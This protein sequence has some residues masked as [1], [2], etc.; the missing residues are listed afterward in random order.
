MEDGL[1]IIKGIPIIGAAV[2]VG[3]PVSVRVV[4]V[5]KWTVT[6]VVALVSPGAD[7]VQQRGQIEF[8]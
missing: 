3:R 8:P 6:G 5:V 1:G 7:G 2:G 4:G